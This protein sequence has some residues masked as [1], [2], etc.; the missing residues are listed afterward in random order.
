MFSTFKKIIFPSLFFLLILSLIIYRGSCFLTEGILEG[1]EY[2]FYAYAKENGILNGLFFVFPLATYFKLWTNIAGI[3]ASPF[4]IDTAKIITTYFTLTAYFLIFFY[5]FFSNSLLFLNI[6]QK[7]FAIFVILFSPLM[8]PEIWMSGAHIREY[9]GIF[10]FTLL[11][12]NPKNDSKTK[13]IFSNILIIISFLSSVWAIVLSP[14]YFVKYY[15]HKTRDNLICFISSLSA[16]LIQLI[17]IFNFYFLNL[18]GSTRFQIEISKIFSF[19][20][21]VPVRSFFGSTIP[22]S[23][24][25]NTNLIYSSYFKFII[26]LLFILLAVLLVIYIIKKKDHILYLILFSFILMSGF[27]FAG[28]LYSN[29]VGGRYAVVP[30]VILIFFVLRIFIIENN[31]ILKSIS[32]FLLLSSLIVGIFEYKYKSPLPHLLSC[33]YHSN[34]LIHY[35]FTGN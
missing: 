29:F 10:A 26:F 8:T 33:E 27:A 11:F 19:I 35:G 31:L 9:F 24:F 30:G 28:S 20:Y 21:N 17:I 16:S 12:Y 22:K 18:T 7:V 25:L 14:V 5:I 23:L 1:T 3:I 13:K 15:F 6:K 34:L 32:G 4:S 2:Q